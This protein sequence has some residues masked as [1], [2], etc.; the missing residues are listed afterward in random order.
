M[1]SILTFALALLVQAPPSDERLAYGNV[2]LRVPEGWKAETRDEGLYLRPSDLKKDES[3]VV[4]IPPGTTADVNLAAGFERTWKQVAGARKTAKKA[5]EKEIK[6][7]GGVDGLMSV[8]L[9]DDAADS[10]LIAAVA[11]FKPADRFQAVLALTADDRVFQ[12][13]SEPFGALIKGLR[14]RNVELPAYDLVMSMGFTEKAGKTTVYVLF[15][16]GTWLPFL[17]VGGLDQVD[18]AK[19][20]S[21]KA[22]GTRP[23]TGR[24]GSQ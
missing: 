15:R 10:R 9:M 11:L 1:M 7:E 4:I 6:T 23:P 2:L 3:Y 21:E 18:G 17:P 13:Y 24:N 22:A 19:A 8:G 20:K 14:F 12:R 5:P 16:D